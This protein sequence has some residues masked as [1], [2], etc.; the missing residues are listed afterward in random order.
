MRKILFGDSA[1]YIALFK[2]TVVKTQKRF[3]RVNFFTTYSE[4][5]QVHLEY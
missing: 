2:K 1:F 4:N 5:R 3:V